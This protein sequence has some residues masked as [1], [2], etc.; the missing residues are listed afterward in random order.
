MLEEL[1]L[2][3]RECSFSDSLERAAFIEISNLSNLRSLSLILLNNKIGEI[4]L[5]Q[6]SKTIEKLVKLNHLNITLSTQT[7]NRD[8]PP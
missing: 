6:L 8:T 7:I 5:D 4:G 3:T 2:Q 1:T